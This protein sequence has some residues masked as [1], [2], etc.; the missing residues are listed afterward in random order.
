MS[1]TDTFSPSSL[2]YTLPTIV[3][4]EENRMSMLY[5]GSY[6]SSLRTYLQIHSSVQAQYLSVPSTHS[7]PFQT[8]LHSTC[9]LMHSASYSPTHVPPMEGTHSTTLLV[10]DHSTNLRRR[11]MPLPWQTMPQVASPSVA[12]PTISMPIHQVRW[13]ASPL[14]HASSHDI[15]DIVS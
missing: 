5:P 2:V 13:V 10:R 1:C 9:T 7:N 6:C 14:I 15:V 3:H 8:L 11:P 4:S 12:T